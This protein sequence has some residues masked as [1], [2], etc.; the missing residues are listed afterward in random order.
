MTEMC[1]SVRSMI[2][3]SAIVFAAI[4]LNAS[5][6]SGQPSLGSASSFAVLGGPAVTCTDAVVVGEVGVDLGGAVTQTNCTVVGGVHAGDLI[7]QQA[8]DDF[9]LAYADLAAE[10]CDVDLTGQPLAGQFSRQASIVLTRRQ[11][12]RAAC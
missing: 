5:A 4:V 11:P 12:R 6:A 2:R 3:L 8:Y 10:P 9:L 1:F 7:A